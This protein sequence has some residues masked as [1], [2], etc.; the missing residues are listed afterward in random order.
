MTKGESFGVS[1]SVDLSKNVCFE[2]GGG[3][4]KV[5]KYVI[6]ITRSYLGIVFS[7]SSLEKK[8]GVPCRSFCKNLS[9]M[10]VCELLTF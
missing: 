9:E 3:D 10:V 4:V 6:L 5:L 1:K 7:R 8:S 2:E